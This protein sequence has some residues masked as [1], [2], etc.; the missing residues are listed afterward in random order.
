MRKAR[1]ASIKI[2]FF[3]FFLIVVS[4]WGSY[5]LYCVFTLWRPINPFYFQLLLSSALFS[6]FF[7]LAYRFFQFFKEQKYTCFIYFL[8]ALAFCF[9]IFIFSAF[10]FVENKAGAAIAMFQALSLHFLNHIFFIFLSPSFRAK[11]KTLYVSLLIFPFLLFYF[12][13]SSIQ[14]TAVLPLLRLVEKDVIKLELKIQNDNFNAIDR[15][16][17][18]IYLGSAPLVLLCAGKKDAA[19]ILDSYL[20]GC[21]FLSYQSFINFRDNLL[22]QTCFQDLIKK[23]AL[24]AQ[25]IYKNTEEEFSL[26]QADQ[27]IDIS[28]LGLGGKY[29][30]WRFFFTA[31]YLPEVAKAKVSFLVRAPV[32]SDRETNSNQRGPIPNVTFLGSRF[33]FP[34]NLFWKSIKTYNYGYAYYLNITEDPKFSKAD[35]NK[36]EL[37]RWS[38]ETQIRQQKKGGIVVRLPAQNATSSKALK[39]TT[40]RKNERYPLE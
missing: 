40:R 12:L 11:H 23:V 38:V 24:R 26:C 27:K 17:W 14:R 37:E 33:Y 32:F 13:P 18:S 8:G 4:F 6:V 21:L 28:F 39:K 36:L 22:K 19:V 7:L 3:L 30:T 29:D 25:I 9:H 20:N 16:R 5:G 10:V 1:V 35:Y 31:T 15:F 34:V 2:F